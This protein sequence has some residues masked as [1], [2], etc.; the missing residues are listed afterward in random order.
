MHG[1]HFVIGQK[2]KTKTKKRKMGIFEPPPSSE[3]DADALVVQSVKSEGGRVE[4][5]H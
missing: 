3:D 1:E 2:E 5:K 4:N